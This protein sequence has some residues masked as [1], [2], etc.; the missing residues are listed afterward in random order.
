HHLVDA[1]M[2]FG[3]VKQ[4]GFGREQGKEQLDLFLETKTVWINYSD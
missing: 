2:P 1:S 4:S 3:G